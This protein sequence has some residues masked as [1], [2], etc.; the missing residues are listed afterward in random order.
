MLVFEGDSR[1]RWLEG[2]YQA[3]EE[4]MRKDKGG[5]W[6]PHRIKYRPLTRA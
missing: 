1:V 4:Q 3:Y 6:E 5:D 2:N